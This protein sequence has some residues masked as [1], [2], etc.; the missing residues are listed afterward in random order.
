[1]RTLHHFACALACVFVGQALGK[2]GNDPFRRVCLRVSH[3]WPLN[4]LEYNSKDNYQQLT[5][6]ALVYARMPFLACRY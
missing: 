2:S 4:V 5:Q 3:T 1:M 6:C